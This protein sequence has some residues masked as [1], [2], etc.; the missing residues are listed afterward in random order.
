MYIGGERERA[1]YAVGCW[2]GVRGCFIFLRGCVCVGVVWWCGCVLCGGGCVIRLYAVSGAQ[3]TDG[4]EPRKKH[5]KGN[6][7]H[8][9]PHT[10]PTIHR[11]PAPP[12][13]GQQ[14]GAVHPPA[15]PVHHQRLLL[16]QQRQRLLQPARLCGC[17][18][19]GLGVYIYN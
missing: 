12:Q 6:H 4:C 17:C 2:G 18:V 5:F 14:L 15:E 7:P 8:L 11:L 19:C 3:R 9:H 1:R 16:V 13:Q 10:K